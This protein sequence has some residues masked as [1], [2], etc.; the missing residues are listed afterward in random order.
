MEYETTN[1]RLIKTRGSTTTRVHSASVRKI[2]DDSFAANGCNSLPNF[3]LHFRAST[4]SAQNS[5]RQSRDARQRH[6]LDRVA[7]ISSLIRRST[8][9]VWMCRFRRLLTS[10]YIFRP[11]KCLPSAAEHYKRIEHAC[12]SEFVTATC[13]WLLLSNAFSFPPQT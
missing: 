12:S 3:L 6:H 5:E 8:F 1:E 9:D 13:E 10:F 11:H 7:T 2:S 4:Q